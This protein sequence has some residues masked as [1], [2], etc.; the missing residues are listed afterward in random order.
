MNGAQKLDDVVSCRIT[1]QMRWWLELRAEVDESTV[2]DVV[3]QM[4]QQD[5]VQEVK[6]MRR[7]R[8]S[9]GVA[10]QLSLWSN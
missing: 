7:H 5:A 8:C 4:I 2:S 3:R 9:D 10:N 1:Q 6:A